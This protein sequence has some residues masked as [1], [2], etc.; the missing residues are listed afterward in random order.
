MGPLVIL[1]EG[2][3][4]T[5]KQYLETVKKYFVLFYHQIVQKYGPDIVIQE[6]NVLWHTAKIV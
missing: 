6:D 4:M 3:Q 5:T 2:E 1:E